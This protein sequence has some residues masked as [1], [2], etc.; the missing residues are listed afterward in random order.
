MFLALH[1]GCAMDLWSCCGA[2]SSMSNQMLYREAIR[3]VIR[4]GLRTFD[5]GRSQWNTGTYRFKEQ[6]GARAVLLYYQY[7]F[8][9]AAEVP[10]FAAQQGRRHRRPPWK[11][12]PS[13]PAC[14]R[15]DPPT[16]PGAPDCH[17]DRRRVARH[18]YEREIAPRGLLRTYCQK[19]L[20]LWARRCIAP[21]PGSGST[22]AWACGSANVFVGLDTYLDCQFP[23]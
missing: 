8:R 18:R 17:E 23:S 9:G 1:R 3:E 21:G 7:V 16:L 4:R 11:R 14:W 5:F 22:A 19:R 13:S 20:H 12:L 6:W 10:N 2:T 15:A